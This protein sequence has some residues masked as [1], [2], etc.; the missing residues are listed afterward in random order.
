MTPE[1][2]RLD[3]LVIAV[4]GSSGSGKSSVSR[5]VA[6]VLGLGCLDTG[7]MYRA[8]ACAALDRGTDLQDG[9]A[10]AELA[11]AAVLEQSTDPE[12]ESVVIDGVDVTAAI[13]EPRVSAVVSDVARNL[14]V[15]AELI[16]RQRAVAAG[17][18]VVIEGRD[19]TTVVIPDA[20]V[21]LLL[22]ADPEARIA[23]RA[24]ELHGVA[25][26]EA[27]AA[28]RDSIVLRD[29]RDSAVTS[30][31]EAADGVTHIDTSH[32]GFDEVVQAVLA[33]V[34]QRVPAAAEVLESAR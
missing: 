30:F 33:A 31:L 3:A 11:R 16:A 21:R 29:A 1:T 2:P 32:L 12:H 15:R 22:S 5:R 23:R 24:R 17:G 18:G 4:D 6:A 8:V 14:D 9:P 27:L 19:I 13:R 26:A 34:V 28:T 25:D 7:A 10:V 20:P